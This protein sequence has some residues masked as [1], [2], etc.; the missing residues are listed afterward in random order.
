MKKRL[1][2]RRASPPSP[3]G[4]REVLVPV[5]TPSPPQRQSWKAFPRLRAGRPGILIRLCT[6]APV[7][8]PDR[9]DDELV[10]MPPRYKP[11]RVVIQ[12]NHPV[13][14]S[15][16]FAAKIE[17]LLRSGL[18]VRSQTVLL[19]GVNDSTDTLETLFAGLVRVGVDPYYLFQGDMAAGTSHFRVPLSRGLLIYD[20][21]RR[22]LSGLE[23]PRFALDDPD[24]AGKMYLPESVAGKE[25]GSGC[26]VGRTAPS[27][28]TRKR[29]SSGKGKGPLIPTRW[30]REAGR[31]VVSDPPDGWHTIRDGR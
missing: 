17:L 21:L 18:P 9:I 12:V 25:D 22:R 2:K 5:A 6:R 11:L 8:L 13:E 10:A 29:R 26:F 23:R 15:P 16:I 27:T 1:R 20:E 7:T 19:R 4:V 28:A 31:N 30:W 24:G 3:S 14:I